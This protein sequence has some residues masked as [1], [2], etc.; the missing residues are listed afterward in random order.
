MT[1]LILVRHGETVWNQERRYQGQQDSPLSPLGIR[2][3]Q[4]TGKFLA[5]EKI[6][7]VYSSDL[8]RAW[9]TAQ[10]IAKHHGLT[11]LA[12]PRL[13]E[14]SFGVWEGLTRDEIM[15]EYPD[16]FYARYQDSLTTR[17]P[18]GELPPEVVLRFQDFLDDCLPNHE[19]ETIVIVSHGGSLRLIIANLL[20]IPLEKSY[21]IHLG[22]A[23]IS[24][25]LYT[26]NG[27]QCSWEVL[28]LNS[29][30]HLS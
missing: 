23:G 7:A 8:Q 24:E 15:I 3:A 4:E 14:M 22:N 21:C 18:N 5:R 17:I 12:D 20:H 29:R 1:R 13:R 16:L 30:G 27:L 26:R 11:P 25:L 6:A 19:D 9:T 10:S 28:T 2:Q